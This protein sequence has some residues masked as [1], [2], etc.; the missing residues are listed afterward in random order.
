[1]PPLLTARDISKHFATRLLFS[2]VSLQVDER[3]RIAL[4]GPNG[5]GKSTLVKILA[6][7]EEAEDGEILPRRG[8][9]AAYVEQADRFDEGATVHSAVVD[10]LAEAAA[11]GKLAHLHDTHEF[12][13]AADMTIYR[14]GLGDLMETECSK[15][16][17]GQRKR[18]SIARG[19]AME[20]D[21]LML[22]EPTNH[23]DVEGIDWLEEVLSTGDFASIVVTHDRAFLEQ[24]ATRIVELS[25][26]YP[27]GTFSVK[28]NYDEFLRRKGEFLDAQAEHERSLSNQVRDDLRWLSRGAKARRTKSKSRIDASYQ[29]MDQLA[30]LRMRNATQKSARIDFEATGRETQKL[31]LGRGLR[32]AY[33][34]KVLFENLDILLTPGSILGLMGP[35]GSGKSTLIR[36]LMGDLESDPP[37]AQMLKDDEDVKRSLPKSTPELGTISRAD[38]LR[39]V[40]F[41]QHRTELDPDKTLGETLSPSDGVVYRGR[42]LHIATWAEMFLF[43]KAQLRTPIKNLSGGEQARV[44]IAKLMLEPADVLILDEPTNDL[45]LASLEV[46][47]ESL[48]EFP[49]AIVLVTHDRAMLDRLATKVLAL[50]GEGGSRYFADYQQWHAITRAE[51]KAKAKAAK[52]G[53]GKASAAPKPK[54]EAKAELKAEA[55]PKKKLT[56]TE[57]HELDHMEKSIEQA[58]AKVEELQNEIGK[59][60]VLADHKKLAAIGVKL[61]EAQKERDR[62]YARWA[63]LEERV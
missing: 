29:R 45:D 43:T 25:R 5:A 37:T 28:G 27:D 53:G 42:M 63:E 58:E 35:N 61:A 44:H 8:L 33:G 59:P 31:L 13:I 41:S 32:K 4:I 57:K 15:L 3:E 23:L 18:L 14:V 11:A 17:G 62:L 56:F 19:L 20:P 52:S 21:L 50:D 40:L 51:E 16:S 30:E 36:M 48:E 9:I 39:I 2:G 38:K 49:G 24:T 47:E 46:L 55:A 7:L 1:M 54:P 26:A 6:G 10:A 34:E 22:D 60:E 12:E